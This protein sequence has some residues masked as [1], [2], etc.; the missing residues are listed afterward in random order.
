ME[1]KHNPDV[2]ITGDNVT[3]TKSD[4]MSK[5]LSKLLQYNQEEKKDVWNDAASI[6]AQTHHFNAFLMIS[7]EY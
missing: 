2:H 3:A 1:E 7:Y 4:I 6:A 5:S